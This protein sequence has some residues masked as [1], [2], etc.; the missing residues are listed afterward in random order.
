M[1]PQFFQNSSIRKAHVGHFIL[2]CN[3][4]ANA[5]LKRAGDFNHAHRAGIKSNDVELV[6][7]V[8]VWYLPEHS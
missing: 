7:F 3:H 8:E 2:R 4:E 1:S 6:V 5:A